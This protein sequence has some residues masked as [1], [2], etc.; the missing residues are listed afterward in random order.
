MRITIEIDDAGYDALSLAV[1][2]YG[3]S[4]D[5]GGANEGEEGEEIYSRASDQLRVIRI[6]M[7][8][9]LAAGA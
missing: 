7:N 1:D 5:E 8:E 2:E 3:Y 9:A 4:V 6:A